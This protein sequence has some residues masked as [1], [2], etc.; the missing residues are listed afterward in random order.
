M[1]AR[2]AVDLRVDGLGER[3]LPHLQRLPVP[4]HLDV[5]MRRAPLI[6][7]RVNGGKR[8]LAVRIGRLDAPQIRLNSLTAVLR[9]VAGRVSLPDF[10]VCACQRTATSARVDHRDRYS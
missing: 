1:R 6:P 8:H 4:R 10:H 7:A 9:I 2:G 3:D 5:D